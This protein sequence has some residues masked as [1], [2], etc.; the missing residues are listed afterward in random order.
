MTIKT[1][2]DN[3]REQDTRGTFEPLFVVQQKVRTWGVDL[4]WTDTYEW[5]DA[6]DWELRPTPQQ[7]S[8]LERSGSIGDDRW[9]KVGYKDRWEFVT[10][11]LTELGCEEFIRAHGHNLNEPRIDC[12]S[13]HGNEEMIAVRDMFSDNKI[14]LTCDGCGGGEGHAASTCDVCGDECCPDCQWEPEDCD[15]LTICFKCGDT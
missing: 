9:H 2:A 8:D 5:I 10:A 14:I 3:I 1:I 11:C 15:V 6:D 7:R 12:V 13:L 4:A